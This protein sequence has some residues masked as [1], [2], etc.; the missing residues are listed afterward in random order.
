MKLFKK[1]TPPLKEVITGFAFLCTA[2]AFAVEFDGTGAWPTGGDVEIPA[3]TS[4]TVLD[5]NVA[6]VAGWDTLK[7]NTGSRL[8]FAN[9]QDRAILKANCSGTGVIAADSSC[10]LTILGDNSALSYTAYFTFTNSIVAVSNEFGLGSSITGTS[11]PMGTY[12]KGAMIHFGAQSQLHFGLADRKAFTNHCAITYNVEPNL[13]TAVFGSD[14]ADEYFVQ[15]G[16]F[17][18]YQVNNTRLVYFR[19]NFQIISGRF[20]LRQRRG[21]S[22]YL[23]TVDD[24]VNVRISENTEFNASG[25]NTTLRDGI[26]WLGGGT[27]WIEQN[28]APVLDVF[29]DHSGRINVGSE[30]G[31]T[32]VRQL[33]G[34]YIETS[35]SNPSRYYDLHGHDISVG[36]LTSAYLQNPTETSTGFNVIRSTEP[37]TVT[38]SGYSTTS[39]NTSHAFAFSGQTSVEMADPLSTNTFCTVVSDSIGDLTVSA[40]TLAFK[41]KAGWSGT[42]VMVK[43]T[44][45]L[46]VNSE[47]AFTSG[48]Q[49]LVVEDSGV[50][51]IKT[52][53]VACFATVTFGGKSLEKGTYS[54]ST[55]KAD[56]DIAD[57]IDGDAGAVLI[58]EGEKI[59]WKG[60]PDEPGAT[61]VVPRDMTVEITDA[62]VE[63]VSKLGAIELGLDSTVNCINGEN[64]LTLTAPVSGLGTFRIVNSAGVTLLG[65]NSGLVAPGSFYVENSALAVSN[66][67]GLG[68]AD[69]GAAE[70]KFGS[71]DRKLVF[72]LA[73]SLFCTNDVVLKLSAVSGAVAWFGTESVESRFV[74]NADVT[75]TGFTTYNNRITYGGNV[76][77]ASGT[78]TAGGGL[79]FA[80]EL[81][82][83]ITF[84]SDCTVKNAGAASSALAFYGSGWNVGMT[85]V[86]RVYF[87]PKSFSGFSYFFNSTSY[88]KFLAENVFAETPGI[89]LQYNPA[90]VQQKGRSVY[91]FCGCDQTVGSFGNYAG[92]AQ[93]KSFVAVTSDAPATVTLT[94]E[95]AALVRDTLEFQGYMGYHYNGVGTNLLCNMKSTSLGDFR[96]SSGVAGFDW[97][98][99][100]G[101]TNIVVD[102]TGT[103]Y[104][105]ADSAPA[106]GAKAVAKTSGVTLT[107]KDFGKLY[108][109]GGETFVGWAIRDGED[110]PRGTYTAANCDWIEGEGLLRVL[111]DHAGIVLIVR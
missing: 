31:F 102:G 36:T 49:K 96:V 47:R 76:E 67:F 23:Y 66:R 54:V 7:V 87:G 28:A 91:E 21:N 52:G 40:G 38:I 19:N 2:G 41:W 84:G 5:E 72:G 57:Y 13:R 48:D 78:F 62:D 15:D 58:V 42:N 44:G 70:I 106:F 63:K 22:L 25:G 86:S 55:L 29:A 90:T 3:N 83:S 104:V 88:V 108:L 94:R 109:E 59:V 20:P 80:G 61:A 45:V 9:V 32:G 30:N 12:V 11:H 26:Y 71:L 68:C 85:A 56:P 34:Y 50:L 82:A 51:R 97:G 10:G 46:E 105:S 33:I 101:G 89:V 103:L 98:A 17:L 8:T 111:R 24:N 18:H 27:V 79:Y 110:I 16:D 60:W 4:I 77:F 37:A 95:N 73:D 39:Y 1:L 69:T 107:L 92:T 81:Y 53:G 65:D 64:Y 100:W 43:G 6:A 14:A 74:Q 99:A 75:L 35:L 93:N